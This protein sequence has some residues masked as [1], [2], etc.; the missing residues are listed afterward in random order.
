MRSLVLAALIAA[1]NPVMAQTRAELTRFEETSR[2]EEVRAFLD[3][4]VPTGRVRVESFGR[5]E[6]GRELPVAII[7]S[8]PAAARPP[9]ATSVPVVLVLANIHAGEV[10][11]KEASLHLMRRMVSGDLQPLLGQAA[12]LFA[13]IYNADGNER[14]SLENRVEQ[15]GPIGGVGTRVNANGLDLN[16]D[17]MKLDSAEG[18]A[19]AALL[20]RWDP[21]VV[22]DLHTT[23]G[24]YHGYHLTYA[25][26][27]NPNTDPALI[28][29]A[30]ERLL[31]AVRQAMTSRHALRTYS[32]G[33]FATTTAMDAELLEFGATVSGVGAAS[34]TGAASSGG[35]GTGDRVWRT[36]D[37][38][39]RF[40][41]TYVGLRNRIAI[42]SEAYSYLDFA[43]R[44]RVTEAF[45]EEIMRYV[46][47]NAADIT[48][49]TGQADA[50]T[51]AGLTEQGVSFALAPSAPAEILVGAVEK[52]T[53]PRSGREMIAMI[54]QRAVP[55]AMQ[56]F[57]AFA[58][59]QTRRVPSAYVVPARADNVHRTIAERLRSHG[60][61]VRETTVPSPQDVDRFIVNAVQRAERPFQKRQETRVTGTWERATVML[62]PGSLVVSTQ[63]PLGRLVFYLLEPESDDGL[64]TWDILGPA[65]TAGTAHPVLKAR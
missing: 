59:T 41:T 42:L 56:E 52:K 44:V 7:G 65:V 12:W 60:I 6:E 55:T 47:G 23:N 9:R 54:E 22:V 63:Q 21:D 49:L 33:N 29:F 20:A 3:A 32:Y 58:V 24:S 16:R 17:F 11:G 46:A 64:G 27:L 57:G 43:G 1:Q 36:F 14:I 19:L 51:V 48:R 5:S 61:A 2:Y 40:G 35:A 34:S 26:S 15:Y 4:L 45:V 31:P 28:A 30:R 18:R 62:P 13:P 53:N 38:R 39:P 50:A 8:P 37:H 10:E 25:P